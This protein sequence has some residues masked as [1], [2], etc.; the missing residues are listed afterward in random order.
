[1]GLLA[2]LPSAQIVVPPEW[3]RDDGARRMVLFCLREHRAHDE[4]VGGRIAGS[5]KCQ[6]EGVGDVARQGRAQQFRDRRTWVMEIVA[7]PASSRPRWSSPTGCWQ[8]GQAGTR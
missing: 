5:A 2:E 8:T 6:A 3:R 4:F 1:M 7:I